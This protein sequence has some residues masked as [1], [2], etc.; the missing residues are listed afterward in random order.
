MTAQRTLL[1]AD[2][3]HFQHGPM[4]IVLSA[5]GDAE[6]VDQAFE[7][8]WIRFEDLLDDLVT[9]LSLLKSPIS[10]IGECP[11]EGVVAR[12][13][14][15]ACA[16]Y[17]ATFITPMAAVAGSVADEL[18]AFFDRD[19][20]D[21]A[22]V[23]NGGDIA[24]HFSR[25]SGSDRDARPLSNVFRVGLYAD[26]SR[27]DVQQLSDGLNL[28]GTLEVSSDM[29]VRGIATSG[30]RGRS[31][32]LGIADS[33]TVLATTAARADAAA[34][35]I[36]NEVNV[37]DDR[38]LR[39]PADEVKDGSDLGAIPVTVDVPQLPAHLVAQAIQAGTR[40]AEDLQRR[41]LIESAVL[42]CQ[43]QIR[44]VDSR[45]ALADAA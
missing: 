18:I 1:S 21:K 38:I 7:S 20:I 12:R 11:M 19:G 4:D 42:V 10:R 43:G 32:S 6:A 44:I 39:I 31:F 35:M 23:N 26:I 27:L 2:R 16:P 40:R 33:V 17:R 14:W 28:D 13:M 29:P 36:A 25:D 45:V 22:W 41:G 37:A 30:W 8:A 3:W 24:L 9:E 34:S 5:H 15:R